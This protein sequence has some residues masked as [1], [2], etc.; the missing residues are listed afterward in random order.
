[1]PFSGRMLL[2]GRCLGPCSTGAA[3]KADAVD[4][5]VV[6]DHGGVVGI[7]DIDDIDVGYGPVVVVDAA[8]PISAGKADT[9]VA[10]PIVDAAIKAHVR[11]P[12]AAVPNIEAVPPSPIA[13]SPEHA[14][15]RRLHP[16]ARH[17]V[18]AVITVGPVAGRP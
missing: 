5:G 8:T 4:R 3:V 18:V 6:I 11:T 2:G 17:P 16:R 10:E 12:V 1:M 13:R 7:V 14:H 9:G 15:H